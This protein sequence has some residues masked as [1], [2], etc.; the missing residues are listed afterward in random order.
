MQVVRF[1]VIHRLEVRLFVWVGL[2]ILSLHHPMKLRHM[3][4]KQV[5][6]IEMR[7]KNFQMLYLLSLTLVDIVVL[8]RDLISFLH[9]LLT[10]SKCL[11][12]TKHLLILHEWQRDIICHITILLLTSNVR[13]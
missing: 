2:T 1:C 10:V 11:V 4:S 9:D 5:R 7:S 13:L 8:V 3:E 12:L 6:H